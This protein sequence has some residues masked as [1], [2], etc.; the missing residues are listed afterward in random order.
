M[1][2]LAR[3]KGTDEHYALKQVRKSGYHRKNHRERAFA[4]RDILAEA[5]TRWF[6]ELHATFQDDQYVYMVFFCLC[7]VVVFVVGGVS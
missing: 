1:V 7:F 4:E 6:V 3:R 5:R 2:H